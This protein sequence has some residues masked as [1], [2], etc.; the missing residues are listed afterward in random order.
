M[1]FRLYGFIAAVAVS[2]LALWFIIRFFRK[3]EKALEQKIEEIEVLQAK[4]CELREGATAARIQAEQDLIRA[5]EG[6]N[7]AVKHREEAQ[8]LLQSSRRL[9]TQDRLTSLTI[10]PDDSGVSLAALVTSGLIANSI[11]HGADTGRISS[12]DT[13]DS[14]SPK[15][16]EDVSG[17]SVSGE[18]RTYS[19]EVEPT[20][21]SY[22]PP[23]YDSSPSYTSSDSYSSSDSYDSGSGSSWD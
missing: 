22:S 6:L 23:T 9:H 15:P 3:E 12:Y 2:G 4:A 1:D 21:S 5:R 8:A 13:S 19:S 14:G 11:G 16:H 20:R 18:T 17:E 10:R 7:E